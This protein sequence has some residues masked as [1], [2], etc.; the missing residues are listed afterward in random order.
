MNG[1]SRHR[2]DFTDRL[3]ELTSLRLLILRVLSARL[4]FKLFGT[5]LFPETD[6]IVEHPQTLQ[7]L[8]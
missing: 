8:D 7:R 5:Y 4:D 3:P 1:T 2:I 6:L